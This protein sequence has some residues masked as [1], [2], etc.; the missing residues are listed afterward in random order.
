M[1]ISS[2]LSLLLAIV[3]AANAKPIQRDSNRFTLSLASKI[4]AIGAQNLADLDRARASA[5]LENLLAK[6]NGK[7]ADN[8]VPVTNAIVTYTASVGVGSPPTQC[9]LCI[10]L[11]A[12]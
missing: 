12:A 2:T 3:S 7:K 10:C 1:F 5:L 9:E 4:N 8:P 6:K 11:V